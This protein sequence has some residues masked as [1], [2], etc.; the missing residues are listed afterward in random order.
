MKVVILITLFMF[1]GQ[2][3]HNEDLFPDLV[4]DSTEECITL[5]GQLYQERS[6]MNNVKFHYVCE[7]R[8]YY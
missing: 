8:E 1:D 7:P 2:T 6:E 4:L 5:V 3:Y